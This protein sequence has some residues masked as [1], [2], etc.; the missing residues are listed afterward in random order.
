MIKPRQRV[1]LGA[2]HRGFALKENL[3]RYLEKQGYFVKDLGNTV[4]DPDDDYPDF[5][6]KLK[7]KVRGKTRGILI[8]NSGVGVA[9][10]ANKLNGIRAVNAHNAKIA[11]S[12]RNDDDTNVLCLGAN[13]INATLARRIVKTWLSTP[14]SNAKRH[15]RRIQKIKR[16][17]K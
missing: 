2:D 3:K 4:L 11:K 14:F 6:V 16:I 7:G 12:S 1:L 5:A 15:K 17:E 9:I 13:H 10:A 8:C